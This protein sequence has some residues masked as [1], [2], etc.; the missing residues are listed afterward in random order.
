MKRP[1]LHYFISNFF[2]FAQRHFFIRFEFQANHFLSFGLI[3][4]G[5]NKNINAASLR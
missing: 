2:H 5:S 4:H 3:S 1:L